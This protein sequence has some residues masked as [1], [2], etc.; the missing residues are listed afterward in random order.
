M[1]S[2]VSSLSDGDNTKKNKPSENGIHEDMNN[3]VFEANE[4]NILN[5]ALYVYDYVN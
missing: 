5:D 2:S 4:D 3:N 1:N